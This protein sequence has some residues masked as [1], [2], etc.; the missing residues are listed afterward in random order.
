MDFLTYSMLLSFFA[1]LSVCV[2]Y[3]PFHYSLVLVVHSLYALSVYFSCFS[4]LI[5]IDPVL[6]PVLACSPSF[7]L[8]ILFWTIA[9]ALPLGLWIFWQLLT[10]ACPLD[11]T[12]ILIFAFCFLFSFAQ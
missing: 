9:L 1:S 6:N 4:P 8:L 7:D 12:S 5:C 2:G 3:C 11:F 10:P